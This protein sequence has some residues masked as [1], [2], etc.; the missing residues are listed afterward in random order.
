MGAVCHLPPSLCFVLLTGHSEQHDCLL[1]HRAEKCPRPPRGTPSRQVAV[2][3]TR[4]RAVA[5][6]SRVNLALVNANR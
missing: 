6:T 1:T 2:V 4:E 5:R 3:S